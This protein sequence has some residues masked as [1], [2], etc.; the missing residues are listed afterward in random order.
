M[1]PP[2]M[3]Q[4]GVP[5]PQFNPQEAQRMQQAGMGSAMTPPGAPPGGG[6]APPSAPPMGTSGQMQRPPMGSPGQVQRPPM[7]TPGQPPANPKLA[8]AQ[9][10]AQNPQFKAMF[11]HVLQTQGPQIAQQIQAKAHQPATARLQ[12]PGP[13]GGPDAPDLRQA[14]AQ[15]RGGDTMMVHATPGEIMIPPALQTPKIMDDVKAAFRNAGGNPGSAVVGSQE[16]SVNPK[17]GIE[18]HG[19]WASVL[20]VVGGIVGAYFGVPEVGAMAG[21]AIGGAAEGD[22][23]QQIALET[24][25]AGVGS[26]VGGAMAGADTAAS[27]VLGGASDAASGAASGATSSSGGG[28][29]SN[30]FGSGATSG[31]TSAPA[32]ASSGLADSAAAPVGASTAPVSAAAPSTLFSPGLDA[33][34][35]PITSAQANPNSVTMPANPMGSPTPT[36][37]QYGNI[38]PSNVNQIASAN[39]QDASNYA[40]QQPGTFGISHGAWGAGKGA[41]FGAGAAGVLGPLLFPSTAT[42]N[43]NQNTPPG[44]QTPWA[45]PTQTPAQMM[46]QGGP[47]S[48]SP[49]FAGYNPQ[50]SVYGPQYN[51]YPNG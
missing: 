13:Q 46:G 6:M 8:Q 45:P 14:A 49:T 16:A 20:G 22:S 27:G 29:L 23:G 39:S 50:A 31:A 11:Q 51:F 44:F 5:G 2:A 18:E 38:T 12:Q 47:S 37:P 48:R 26:S 32:A 10:L 1:P 34:G 7:G 19:I 3:P 42:Q 40:S 43:V 25:M 28:F 4:Q 36:G 33:G 24:G 41:A 15:G 17:T 35:N 9:Q 30:L 21:T